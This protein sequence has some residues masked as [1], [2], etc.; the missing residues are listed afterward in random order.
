MRIEHGILAPPTGLAVPYAHYPTASPGHSGDLVVLGHGFLRAKERM[1]G[2]ARALAA[3]GITAVALDF[4]AA[5]PWDHGAIRNGLDMIRVAHVL[6]ARRVVYVGFSAGALAAL[7]AARND[8]RAR[9]V[10]VLD[11]VDARGLGVVQAR[12]LER[13]LIALV[14]EPSSCNAYNNGLKVLAAARQVSSGRIAGASHCDFETPTDW[15]CRLV[16]AGGASGG[17]AQRAEVVRRTLVAVR[18]LLP[19]VPGSLDP[20]G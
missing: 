11:L 1:D 9:G 2:L 7:V 10:V 20:G 12:A 3:H 15:L 13:P 4:R 5:R 6:G 14:G 18:D 16:C 17:A 8:P 19:P